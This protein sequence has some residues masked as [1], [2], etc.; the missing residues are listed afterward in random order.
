MGW[1]RAEADR[2]RTPERVIL[3]KD[4]DRKRADLEG[5]RVRVQDM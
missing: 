2:L 3:V 4:Q 5:R 1:I